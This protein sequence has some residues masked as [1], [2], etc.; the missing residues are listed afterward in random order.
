MKVIV[1]IQPACTSSAKFILSYRRCLFCMAFWR[2]RK[3]FFLVQDNSL[4]LPFLCF[5]VQYKF[6]L[7][8]QLLYRELTI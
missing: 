8:F 6:D 4:L 3:W 2:E 7:N 5:P 1:F